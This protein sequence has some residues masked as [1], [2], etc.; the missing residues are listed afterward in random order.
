MLQPTILRLV[1]H[2]QA[3]FATRLVDCWLMCENAYV[4]KNGY[5]DG[6]NAQASQRVRLNVCTGGSECTERFSCCTA[7]CCHGLGRVC[8]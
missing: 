5:K 3:R 6:N 2:L 7:R 4:Y 1:V 8:S